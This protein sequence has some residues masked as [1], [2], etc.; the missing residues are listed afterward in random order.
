MAGW[1]VES[2]HAIST[3]VTAF[4]LSSMWGPK[5]YISQ[6]LIWISHLSRSLC[7]VRR[8]R[9]HCPMLWCS[10][11]S[12]KLRQ[13]FET[14][15]I[16]LCKFWE[17]YDSHFLLLCHIFEKSCEKLWCCHSHSVLARNVLD[18]QFSSYMRWLVS[19]IKTQNFNFDS[20]SYC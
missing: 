2:N 7:L 1:I 17:W 10:P 9:F 12:L 4:P 3:R 18:F 16:L 6:L 8:T 14:Q 20:K 19:V 11:K 13:Y 15:T 5:L